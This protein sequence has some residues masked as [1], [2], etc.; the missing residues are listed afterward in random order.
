MHGMEEAGSLWGR[1]I[2]SV[3]SCLSP[4]WKAGGEVNVSVAPKAIGLRALAV[5]FERCNAGKP[6]VLIATTARVVHEAAETKQRAPR[7]HQLCRGRVWK[8]VLVLDEG[9]R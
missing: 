4:T 3:Q 9:N 2:Q 1:S 6:D 7:A 5:F 8:K